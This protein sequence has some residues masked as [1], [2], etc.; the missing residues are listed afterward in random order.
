M[1]AI[2]HLLPRCLLPSALVILLPQLAGCSKGACES[3]PKGRAGEPFC[4]DDV[5]KSN[6]EKPSTLAD[7]AFHSGTTCTALGYRT[8]VLPKVMFKTCSTDRGACVGKVKPGGPPVAPGMPTTFC[9][10]DQVRRDCERPSRLF[11]YTFS[12]KKC[13]EVGFPKTCIGGRFPPSAR[14]AECPRGLTEKK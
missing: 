6:C 13:A 5:K 1:R 4:L 7:H 14:F 3:I 9:L 10:E 11:D 12:T 2:Q 8:C